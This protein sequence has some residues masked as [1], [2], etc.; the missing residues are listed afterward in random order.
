MNRQPGINQ[1]GQAGLTYVEVLIAIVL[2][3]VSIVP[4]M[5]ALRT[6]IQASSVNETFTSQ[7]FHLQARF[8]EVLALNFSDLKKEAKSVG[9]PTTATAFSDTAGSS[10]R[11]LVYLSLYDGDNKDADNDPFTGM[12]EDLIWVR[13]TI[14]NTPHEFE[15]LTSKH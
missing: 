10:D 5:E 9:S 15:T 4:A 8:E 11:R 3:G 2:L 1:C 7:S 6:G 13:A 12:D 14:E